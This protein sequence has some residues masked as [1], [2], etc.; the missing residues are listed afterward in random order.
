MDEP[1]RIECPCC[2]H[3]LAV[4]PEVREHALFACGHCGMVIR[5]CE[6]SR[7]F[8]WADVDPYVRRN[9]AS[10]ANL[11]GGLIGALAWL[12]VLAL[13]MLLKGG[14]DVRVLLALAGPYL[15]LLAVLR[16]RRARTPAIVWSMELWAGLGAYLLYLH[17]LGL[18]LPSQM[19]LVSS[20]EL[21]LSGPAM[22]VGLGS[23]WLAVGLGGRAW[24]RRRA[25]RL[26]QAMGTP[27]T[28]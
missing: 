26:P 16:G 1:A 7:A 6:G 21:S 22:L 13:V 12:P 15:V 4:P 9:G 28:A 2:G 3:A 8:R 25:A 23:T 10:R 11:W 14:F 19:R 17:V 18:I 24:Y 20:G 5:N 27:P